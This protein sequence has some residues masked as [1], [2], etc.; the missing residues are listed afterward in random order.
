M[1][2]RFTKHPLMLNLKLDSNRH[3]S[4]IQFQ[5]VSVDKLFV[6]MVKVRAE[7]FHKK[8]VEPS[9]FQKPQVVAS[10]PVGSPHAQ[11]VQHTVY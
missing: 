10:V 8:L 2:F 6:N 7:Q 4:V 11:Y 3:F 9:W 1:R 5:S